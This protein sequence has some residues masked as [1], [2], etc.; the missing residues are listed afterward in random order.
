MIDVFEAQHPE[1]KVEIVE[2]PFWDRLARC[3]VA[4]WT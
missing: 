1:C 2:L 4:K 3:G